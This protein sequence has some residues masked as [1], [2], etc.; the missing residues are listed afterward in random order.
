MKTSRLVRF[1]ISCFSLSTSVPLRPMMMPGPRGVDVDLQ[2]VGRALGLDLRDAGV[3]EPLLQVCAQRQVLVQQLRVVA[4]R[5]PARPPRLV[6]PEPESERVNLLAHGYSFAPSARSRRGAVP[7]AAGL[8]RPC[9]ARRRA[10]SAPAR[11]RHGSPAARPRCT[12]RCAVRFS[13]AER[14]PHRRRPHALR[15]RPLV[16]VARR[17]E[18]PVDVAAEPFLL[19]RVGDRRPQHLRDVAGH[20]LARELQRR[21]R[22]VDVLAANEIEHEPGLLGRGPHVAWPL[23][24]LRIMTTLPPAWPRR[25]RR[26]GRRRARRARRRHGG[27]LLRDLRRVP[28]ELARRRELTRACGRPC[29]RSRTPG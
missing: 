29:S 10:G 5:V 21:Q 20:R 27:R 16:R 3:R 14:A 17:H 8:R 9:A 26:A 15:R 7:A 28:L 25:L 12:V 2:L 13:D 6:E 18:E 24:A 22:L 4:V 11:D 19:L 1:W 23:P